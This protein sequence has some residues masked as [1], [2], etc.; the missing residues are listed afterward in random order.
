MRCPRVHVGI[1]ANVSVALVHAQT[2]LIMDNVSNV[3][4]LSSFKQT[5]NVR[6]T[7][8]F[9][10]KL[11]ASFGGCAG[12]SLELLAD[13][14]AKVSVTFVN[15]LSESNINALFKLRAHTRALIC[16]TATVAHLV[17]ANTVNAI[18]LGKR[19][20]LKVICDVLQAARTALAISPRF[21]ICDMSSALV[22]AV[23]ISCL[24][25]CPYYNSR[26]I[27]APALAALSVYSLCATQSD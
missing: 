10:S 18:A 14:T 3:L 19:V 8:G 4:T 20:K 12:L 21:M 5:A 23:S 25:R 9:G 22:H 13:R 7:V 11:T 17:Y 27:D 1:N 15:V 24:T 2:S 16:A 6:V 26:I